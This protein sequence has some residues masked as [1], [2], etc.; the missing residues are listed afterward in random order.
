MNTFAFRKENVASVEGSPPVE[1]PALSA[2]SGKG[3]K[4]II[5]A[6][7]LLIGCDFDA[8]SDSNHDVLD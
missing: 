6:P 7:T 8:H 4:K 1:I 3:V 5:D 2:L